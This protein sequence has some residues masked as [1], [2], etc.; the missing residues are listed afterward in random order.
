MS[1]SLSPSSSFDISSSFLR[2][3]KFSSNSSWFDV[4]IWPVFSTR[5]LY[6]LV[7]RSEAKPRL[8]T[9]TA[10]GAVFP[11]SRRSLLRNI[12]ALHP[13]GLNLETSFFSPYRSPQGVFLILSLYVAFLQSLPQVAAQNQ[14]LLPRPDSAIPDRASINTDLI[15]DSDS[16]SWCC[17][18]AVL[19]LFAAPTEVK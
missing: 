17:S 7:F 8:I 11:F 15:P 14:N 16:P 12:H 3:K 9:S 1:I 6:A 2:G 13:N 4:R 19:Y 5:T 10:L 18:Y